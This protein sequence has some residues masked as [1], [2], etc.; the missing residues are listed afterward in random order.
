MDANPNPSH[1]PSKGK[2]RE[3]GNS[4]KPG[5]QAPGKQN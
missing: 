4:I 3:A 1:S 5:A 2:A